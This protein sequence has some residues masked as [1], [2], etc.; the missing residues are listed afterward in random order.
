[1]KV[2]L[3][4]STYKTPRFL[5]CVLA[6][7]ALQDLKP[8]EVIVTEDG[9]TLENKA[10]IDNFKS[11]LG[12]DLIHLTQEDI[13]NRKPLA[14]NKAILKS[15]G[16]YL[17]FIDGD[18]IVRSD[19]LSTHKEMANEKSFLTGRR[20]DLS[21]SF[22][23]KVTPKL[24]ASGYFN[25][26]PWAAMWDAIVGETDSLGRFFKTPTFFRK[27]L[28]RDEVHDIRGCNFSV[29]K[30]HLE[31]ING[32]S[33]DFSGAYGED[34]D[35]EI[36]LKFLGLKMKSVK[37]AAIQYHLWHKVQQ[38]DSQNQERLDA[39]LK[40]SKSKTTNGLFEALT[41]R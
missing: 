12:S 31:A 27:L 18:C 7:V 23:K 14:L 15:R 10:L 32:F 40:N 3:I 17:I 29:H 11:K 20:V 9:K 8:F 24:V 16:D 34:S 35:V 1:M 22:S 28:K 6:S 33:N 19:F 13:G 36:R 26:L 41:Y 37:G 4:I 30:K 21:E 38:K 2:S 5:E 25:K 39:V